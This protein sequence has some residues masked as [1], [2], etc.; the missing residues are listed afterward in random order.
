MIDAWRRASCATTRFHYG[1]VRNPETWRVVPRV[2]HCADA[3]LTS[4]ASPDSIPP[5]HV[6]IGDFASSWAGASTSLNPNFG[7]AGR[8]A[9]RLPGTVPRIDDLQSA[10][11]PAA[12]ED[13]RSELRVNAGRADFGHPWHGPSIA[14]G[15]KI[16]NINSLFNDACEL[17]MRNQI[18]NAARPRSTGSGTT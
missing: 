7:G 2:S 4:T 16:L 3:E 11:D 1:L 17:R 15:E 12:V 6:V 5:L 10:G 13:N 8:H 18:S 9:E 14:G